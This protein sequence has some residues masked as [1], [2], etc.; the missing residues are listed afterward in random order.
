MARQ[1]KSKLK[2][3]LIILLYRGI[4]QKEFILAGQRVISAYY[5]DVLR[6]LRTGLWQQKTGCC[7]TTM[8][9][10][11]LPFHQQIFDKRHECRPPHTLLLSASS[12]ESV[13][14]RH[15]DKIGV[16][17]AESQAVLDTLTGNDFQ[18]AF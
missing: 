15:F 6:R 11:T 3:M 18:D 13:K 5:C 7:V 14:G 17:E 9:R 16:M 10:L 12:L 8:H 1:A 4:V 2:S